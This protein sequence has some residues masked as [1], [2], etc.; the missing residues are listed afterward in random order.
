MMIPD[1]VEMAVTAFLV[2]IVILNCE[3]SLVSL[4][5]FPWCYNTKQR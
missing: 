4:N 5:C 2:E 3:N 1:K